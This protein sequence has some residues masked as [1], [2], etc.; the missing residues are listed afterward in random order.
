MKNCIS[1]LSLLI[2][3]LVFCMSSSYGAAKA[4]IKFSGKSS[5]VISVAPNSKAYRAR[6]RPG[7]RIIEI[8]G[9]PIKDANGFFLLL[10]DASP[11]DYWEVKLIRRGRSI[12]VKMSL[13]ES[14]IVPEDIAIQRLLY[15]G[16]NI[17]L[18]IVPLGLHL[19]SNMPK[20]ILEE[21]KGVTKNRIL[22]WLESDYS[23]L[24]NRFSNL[25]VVDRANM[26]EVIKEIDFSKSSYISEDV[27]KKM[28]SML[29]ATH[30]YGI[31]YSKN[32]LSNTKT[33]ELWTRKLVEVDT[34]KILSAS[35]LERTT[36]PEGQVLS[37]KK[38][39]RDD[40]VYEEK[41]RRGSSRS[42]TSHKSAR[43]RR[44][45]SR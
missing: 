11:E 8:N 32:S 40:E 2:I 30:I 41:R 19:V 16:E 25:T 35:L 6:I 42:R 21:I 14:D 17:V 9:T 13:E 29:G 1:F 39:W 45:R 26:E 18:V 27:M 43:D 34:G 12:K 33:E 23:E 44:S 15:K 22:G 3:L 31:S 37:E 36:N 28:G 20:D 24:S 5:E 7:D 38:S 10:L 4:D